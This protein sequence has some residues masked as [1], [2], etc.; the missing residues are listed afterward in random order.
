MLA[1]G[2]GTLFIPEFGTL[3]HSRRQRLH[4]AAS[5]GETVRLFLGICRSSGIGKI[6]DIIK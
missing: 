2:G 1:T 6:I 5:A 3:C 4:P